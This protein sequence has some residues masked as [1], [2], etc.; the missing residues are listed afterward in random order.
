MD[1]VTLFLAAWKRVCVWLLL[2][3]DVELSVSPA[4]ACLEAAML[5]AGMLMD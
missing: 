4:H 3:E 2:D 1:F 5:P